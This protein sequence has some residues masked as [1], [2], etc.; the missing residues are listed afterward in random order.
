MREKHPHGHAPSTTGHAGP[1][2]CR[3]DC[4]QLMP[5]RFESPSV[6]DYSTNLAIGYLTLT[7]GPCFR[8]TETA[9]RVYVAFV[10]FLSARFFS[11]P[12]I[13]DDRIIHLDR[14]RDAAGTAVEV[15]QV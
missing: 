9:K 8:L 10:L 13:H 3:I 1:V 6:E 15:L 2:E 14:T 7:P 4:G 5:W 11:S 12:S